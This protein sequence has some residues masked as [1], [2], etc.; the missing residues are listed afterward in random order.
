M[1]QGS[2]ALEYF[3]E[4]QDRV[5][6]GAYVKR[7]GY[8]RATVG[9]HIACLSRINGRNLENQLAIRVWEKPENH[10]VFSIKLDEVYVHVFFT[11]SLVYVGKDINI[12]SW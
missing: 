11:D 1:L 8:R 6:K 2:D 10:T 4:L 12:G 5:S 3:N 7:Y 9:N